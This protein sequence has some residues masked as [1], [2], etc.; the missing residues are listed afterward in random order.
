M[1]RC[2]L[3][4]FDHHHLTGP[5]GVIAAS[6]KRQ[7]S[8]EIPP[9][10]PSKVKPERFS[11][12]GDKRQSHPFVFADRP[13]PAAPRI[14]HLVRISAGAA[15]GFVRHSYYIESQIVGWIA[16][17]PL[18]NPMPVAGAIVIR[19]DRIILI[20]Q[21]EFRA[22]LKPMGDMHCIGDRDL[23]PPGGFRAR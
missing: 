5:D 20:A 16:E 10:P 22:P 2:A 1:I 8:A 23:V 6:I 4:D 15:E 13:I 12:E 14:K 3:Q 21:P 18:L 19:R 9:F 17:I 7:P 11:P